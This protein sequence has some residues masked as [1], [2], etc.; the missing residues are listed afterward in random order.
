M[1]DEDASSL[2][3]EQK[4]RETIPKYP[5]TWLVRILLYV[6]HCRDVSLMRAEMKGNTK[7]LLKD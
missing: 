7:V 6:P 2:C 5:L 3:R 1:R 4:I